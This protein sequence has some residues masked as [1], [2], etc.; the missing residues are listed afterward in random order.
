MNINEIQST[1]AAAK[2]IVGTAVIRPLGAYGVLGFTIPIPK[3][4]II[5]N[6]SDVTDHYS[7]NRQYI[8]DNISQKPIRVTLTGSVYEILTRYKKESVEE[9][10]Q[11]ITNKVTDIAA[12]GASLTQGTKQFISQTQ[13]QKISTLNS[14][15]NILVDSGNLWNAIKNIAPFSS[16]QGQALLFLSTIKK[17]GLIMSIQTPWGYYTNMV[18]ETIVAEQLKESAGYTDLQLVFKQVNFVESQ[19]V[20]ITAQGRVAQQSEEP[21]RVAAT[22]TKPVEKQRIIGSLTNTANSIFSLFR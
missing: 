5:D 18:L 17:I 8:T 7:E 19:N 10:L 14:W 16:Q 12:Y 15:G 20:N 21:S 1:L 3:R 13:S 6:G 11:Q 4:E 9:G 2:D 22:R